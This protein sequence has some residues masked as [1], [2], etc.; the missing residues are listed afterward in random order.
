MGPKKKKYA[1]ANA[2]GFATTSIPKAKPVVQ[3][4]EAS[5]EQ[6]QQQATSTPPA[7]TEAQSSTAQTGDTVEAKPCTP[8]ADDEDAMLAEKLDF[9]SQKR[10]DAFVSQPQLVNVEALPSLKMEQ[11]IENNA[12]RL[13]K[14]LD[15]KSASSFKSSVRLGKEQL[16]AKINVTYLSLL[17]LGFEKD[18]V[19]EALKNTYTGEPEDALDWQ[20]S[21]LKSAHAAPNSTDKQ[22]ILQ[23]ALQEDSDDDEIEDPNER[24][25]QYKMEMMQL[26]E[27]LANMQSNNPAEKKA[28]NRKLDTL[29]SKIND[30][31]IDFDFD[32]KVA[33]Q[34][35]KRRI[36]EEKKQKKKDQRKKENAEA[37]VTVATPTVADGANDDETGLA[38]DEDGVFGGLWG[39]DDQEPAAATTTS[40]DHSK[41]ITQLRMANPG[42]SGGSPKVVLTDFC[43]KKDSR[44]TISFKKAAGSVPA[45]VMAK[46]VITWSN[47]STVTEEMHDVGCENMVEAE[48]YVATKMLFELAP[49]LPL[50]RSLPPTYKDLW[51]EWVKEKEADIKL[52]KRKIDGERMQFIKS[53]VSGATPKRSAE[54]KHESGSLND[55][56]E[57]DQIGSSRASQTSN[58]SSDQKP[59]T[60]AGQA[61][62][63]NWHKRLELPRH[64]VLFEKRKE[65]PIFQFRQQ[66]LEGL[67]K[68]QVMIVSGETG[69]G[70]STQ[71]P[72]YLAEHMLEL[73]LGDQCDIVCTQPRRISAISIAHR[74]SE[75]L[76]DA[77]NSAGKPNTLVGYQIR[78][79]AKVAPSNILKFCTTGILLR[80][81]ESDKT[82]K[83]VTHL[84]ID[85]VH[86]RT[87]ESDLLLII[88]KKLL[89]V[90][91]DLRVIL[92]SATVD[93]QRFSSYFGDCPILEVPGRT[94]PVHAHFL[95]DVV[96]A[97]GYTLEEDSEYA[98]QLQRDIQDQGVVYVSGKGA[99][100]QRVALRYDAEQSR[101][102]EAYTS[103]PQSRLSVVD[104]SLEQELTGPKLPNRTA[105]MMKR[106]DENKINY[107]LI[108]LLL[109]FICFPDKQS[110]MEKQH[111]QTFKVPDTGAI[112]IFL[113]GMPEIRKLFDM[114][115]GHRHFGDE[116]LFSLW[117]LHS[118]IS[119]EGQSQVFDEP[120]PG[121]RKIV[122]ATNIAETGITIPDVT[123][124]IDTGKSKQIKFD[125][126]RRVTQLQERFIARANAR[127]RR[128][129]AGRVQEGICFHLF[130]KETFDRGMPEYQAPEILRMPL[131]E[132]CLMV[133]M[134]ELGK[135]SEVLASALDAPPSKAVEN[136]V[137]ALQSVQALT[138]EEVLTPLG[139]HLANLP[140]DVHTGKMIL[141]GAIFKCLDPIL[142]I[143]AMLSFKPPFVTP[144]GLED[145]VDAAK[146]KFKLADSDM[147]TWYNAYL[148]WRYQF[149]TRPKGIYDYCRKHFLSHQNMAMIEDM[150]KQFL[151]FL[152][153]SGFVRVEDPEKKKQL[154]RDRVLWRKVML[155]PILPEY[156]YNSWS[157]PVVNAAITAGM[158]PKVMMQS[159]E[160]PSKGYT[161]GVRQDTVWIHP[162]S[163]NSSKSSGRSKDA[164]FAS[165]GS[166]GSSPWFVYN[167]L[168]KSTRMYVWESCRI[169]QFPLVLFGGDLEIKHHAKLVTIDK[170]IQFRCHAKTAVVLKSMREELDKILKK[171]IDAPHGSLK[172]EEESW[173]KMVAS[174]L[175]SEQ[176]VIKIDEKSSGFKMFKDH[177]E[178]SRRHEDGTGELISY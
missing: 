19:E 160:G 154:D 16:I 9:V 130:S 95:E 126:K 92:M 21:E 174:I 12:I 136:A 13:L 84:V 1:N 151:G 75:E 78:L 50:Y 109:E 57:G 175:E 117:P 6:D 22:W 176:N 20:P 167:S 18:D 119:S 172:D 34:M 53:L 55:A 123:V 66:I 108:Q 98:V 72:Q 99:S 71:V 161:T 86:E 139:V 74:V 48:N 91:R 7:A 157:I 171:M 40:P 15:A 73:G 5:A 106:I 121:I 11:D 32:S 143:A 110:P 100:K 39:E 44:V 10:V 14:K 76:G 26:Q 112:L 113:P 24:Y 45:A 153:G 170:W 60:R 41:A 59:I 115:K 152:I 177:H 116:K 104:S 165:A 69:C 67:Q 162:S 83:G 159:L 37:S 147:L 89:P 31:N 137:Q 169:G 47:G 135:I 97:T 30:L 52:A 27:E 155:C 8:E 62:Q 111:Q 81:L 105:Q 145:E 64:M 178:N 148:G 158:Y 28:I 140:V 35:L 168:I 132:I 33:E 49:S 77:R 38:G 129:R 68:H 3:P 90:R 127:Q 56:K 103:E 70:K 36:N 87:I 156:N 46:V 118:S 146:A 166:N 144:F 4:S 2:R 25:V 102:I 149:E 93:A 54:T 65:L 128:G 141:F 61:L 17:R 164:G 58:A 101:D 85:E 150:K 142:T 94:F 163:V 82:L 29:R 125:E 114:L 134:C 120:P 51:L 23:Q 107:D 63:E 42:W 133:K 124:V 122:L 96:D 138:A 88:L 80:R 43:R 173:L 79:E 131:E